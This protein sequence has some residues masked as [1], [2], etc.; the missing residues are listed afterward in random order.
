MSVVPVAEEGDRGRWQT[1]RDPERARNERTVP[2]VHI[3]EPK[4]PGRIDA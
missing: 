2:A 4:A 3:S 1:P